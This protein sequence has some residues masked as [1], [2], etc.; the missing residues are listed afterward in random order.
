MLKKPQ[1][2]TFSAEQI[3]RIANASRCQTG[4]ATVIKSYDNDYP[5]FDVPIDQ[6]VLVYIPNHTVQLADGTVDIR[7]D[8]FAAHPYTNGREFGNLRCV[9]SIEDESLKL[10]G[11]CPICEAVNKCW[12]LYNY[13]YEELAKSRGFV[14]LKAEATRT[15]LKDESKK[16]LEARAIKQAEVWLTFPI[17][18]IECE[19]GAD[20]KPTTKPKLDAEGK[21]VGHPM[22][23]SVREKT[24]LDKWVSSLESI[25]IN[26]ENPTHP[27]GLWATLNFTYQKSGNEN[28]G[29]PKMLSAKNL[30]VL[31]KSPDPNMNEWN[32]YFDKMTEGWTPQKAMEVVV[33]DCVRDM[34]EIHEAVDTIMKSTIERL[35]LYETVASANNTSAQVIGTQTSAQAM[36][37][38]FGAT[39]EMSAPPTNVGVQ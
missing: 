5:V 16:L 21:I 8:K 6:K 10:D 31:F 2:K 13:Q 19:M 20:G 28:A 39:N 12:E 7:A 18:V 9:D 14:D 33:L 22:W 36:L 37:E 34:D 38:S 3:D 4:K 1:P 17:V 29:N 35:K 24:Y 32:A 11:T 15:A 27:A 30:K 23:Y 25:E 26:G